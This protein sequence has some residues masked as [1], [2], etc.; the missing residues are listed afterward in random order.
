MSVC[1]AIR[2][3][4]SNTAPHRSSLLVRTHQIVCVTLSFLL[5]LSG[6]HQDRAGAGELFPHVQPDHQL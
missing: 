6:M 1:W 3:V 2:A 5:L 4:G